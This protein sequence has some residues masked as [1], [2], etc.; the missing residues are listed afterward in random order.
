QLLTK[1]KTLLGVGDD[2]KTIN[3]VIGTFT[4]LVK[5]SKFDGHN[6]PHNKEKLKENNEI[7]E[8]K[9]VNP[10]I[11][12]PSNKNFGISYTINLNLPATTEIDVYNS[13]FKAL[14]DN[15]LNE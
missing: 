12:L 15:L 10:Q 3:K 8:P 9:Q 2:D 6:E 14:K 4:E 13:I 11:N 1:L 5:L 7:I